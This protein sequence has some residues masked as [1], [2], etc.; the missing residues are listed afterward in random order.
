ME[1]EK[2]VRKAMLVRHVVTLRG[3]NGDE[4]ARFAEML[5]GAVARPE[6]IA[7]E[8]DQGMFP[9]IILAPLLSVYQLKPSPYRSNLPNCFA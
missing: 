3:F 4:G 6:R 2:E 5:V 1:R 9:L 8:L 7:M